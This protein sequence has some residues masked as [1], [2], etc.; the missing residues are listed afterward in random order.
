MAFWEIFRLESSYGVVFG[1]EIW[2]K[3][4]MLLRVREGTER[5]RGLCSPVVSLEHRVGGMARMAS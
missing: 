1:T 5:T 2:G 3:M 4:L